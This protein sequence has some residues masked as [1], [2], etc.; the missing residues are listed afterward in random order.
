MKTF[1]KA[2][3]ASLTASLVDYWVTIVLVEIVGFWYVWSSALG[4]I[5]G[6]ITNFSM[7]RKWV[8][9]SF[10]RQAEVQLIRYALVWTGYLLLSTSGVFLLTSY[11]P[12]TY[13]FSKLLV[14]V[15]MGISYNYPLQK[16]F[17]F[18]KK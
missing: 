6:G 18:S 17:V 15:F 3:V 10:S 16:K 5:L 7:G 2:Q 12:L 11:T 14:S 9:R 8:F 1:A 4:T 13:I